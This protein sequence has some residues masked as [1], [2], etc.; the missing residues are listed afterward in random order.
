MVT[1]VT[2]AI[3][4]RVTLRNLL[5]GTARENP[6]SEGEGDAEPATTARAAEAYV[7]DIYHVDGYTELA[8][9]QDIGEPTVEEAAVRSLR[10]CLLVGMAII[11]LPGA[12]DAHSEW[13]VELDLDGTLGNGPDVAF[14]TPG[15]FV[16]MDVWA[17][18]ETAI[19]GFE[20]ALCDTQNLLDLVWRDFYLPDSWNDTLTIGDDC[21]IL[22]GHDRVLTGVRPGAGQKPSTWSSIKTLFRQTKPHPKMMILDPLA[23]PARVATLVYEALDIGIAHVTVGE[24][25]LVDEN[26]AC[27]SFQENV[28]CVIEIHVCQPS[29]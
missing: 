22:S 11:L 8:P 15:D 7:L 14:F 2:G 17:K 24:S 1:R 25:S 3:P 4:L 28:G 16:I 13:S 26:Y 5:W 6:V 18:G 20:V 23:L 10:L 21:I 19:L 9:P 27:G 12:K 29:E